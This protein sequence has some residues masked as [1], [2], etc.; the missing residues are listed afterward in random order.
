MLKDTTSFGMAGNRSG[1]LLITSPTPSPLSHLTPTSYLSPTS[2]LFHSNTHRQ[3][4]AHPPSHTHTH[5]HTHVHTYTDTNTRT[6]TH[7]HT[8]QTSVPTQEAE[9]TQQQGTDMHHHSRAR[10]NQ[11]RRTLEAFIRENIPTPSRHPLLEVF[12]QAALASKHSQ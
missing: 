3:A 10:V 5:T 6:H 1:N 2:H 9:R 4:L 7:S 8:P 11:R 12:S